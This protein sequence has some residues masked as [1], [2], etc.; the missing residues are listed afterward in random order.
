MVITVVV[1]TGGALAPKAWAPWLQAF[2]GQSSLALGLRSTPET[3]AS[4]CHNSPQGPRWRPVCLPA[5]RRCRLVHVSQDTPVLADRISQYCLIRPFGPLA[6]ADKIFR[7][8]TS[9]LLGQ[10]GTSLLQ[11][12]RASD[13]RARGVG[14]CCSILL[15]TDCEISYGYDVP[16]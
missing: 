1:I 12:R 8:C 6:V 16:V 2:T 7:H 10:R 3:P 9:E 13:G 4:S 14:V 5:R 11:L 15:M